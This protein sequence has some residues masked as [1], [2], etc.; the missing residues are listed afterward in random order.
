MYYKGV[1]LDLENSPDNPRRIAAGP[2]GEPWIIDIY[3]GI[4][5]LQGYEWV[6]QYGYGRD[7]GCG[8]TYERIWYID[9]Y[10]KLQ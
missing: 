7:I 5:T 8:S 2:A 1:W 9:V 4:Y 3:G 10:G 6:K